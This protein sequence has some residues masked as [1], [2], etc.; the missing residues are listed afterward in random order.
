MHQVQGRTM[1]RDRRW[2]ILGEDGR[3]ITIGR[4][5]DP[6]EAELTEVS[7]KLAAAGLG[8]WLAVVEGSYYLP[9]DAVSLMRVRELTPS[10]T[11]WEDAVLAF[12][13]IR[14]QSL[15]STSV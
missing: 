1:E 13:R 10:K 14:A 11:Q 4:H 15:S 7:Q 2:I 9:G 8:G 6:T 3:H 12:R 5:S